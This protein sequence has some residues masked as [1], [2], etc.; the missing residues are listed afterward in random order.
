M[1][2]LSH[3]KPRSD[4]LLAALSGQSLADKA[5]KRTALY[6]IPPVINACVSELR[7]QGVGRVEV[8]SIK[9]QPGAPLR[10]EI[11]YFKFLDGLEM[12]EKIAE[13]F[14]ASGHYQTYALPV[15]IFAEVVWRK[16]IKP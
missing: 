14:G 3:T 5:T 13:G 16:P 11:V 8:V 4:L 15:G 9:T 10:L 2:P 7:R 12:A 1:K 6:D